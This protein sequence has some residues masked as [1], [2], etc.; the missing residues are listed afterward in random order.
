MTEPKIK[1]QLLKTLL[2]KI[3]EHK[4]DV[5]RSRD[6]FPGVM[7]AYGLPDEAIPQCQR[8][9]PHSSNRAEL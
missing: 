8:E 2:S 5:V 4:V 3:D 1:N 9:Y 6:T 7:H